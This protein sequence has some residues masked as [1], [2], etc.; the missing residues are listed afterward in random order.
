MILE[1]PPEIF[2]TLSIFRCRNPESVLKPKP[3]QPKAEETTELVNAPLDFELKTL[4]FDH[5]Y[6]RTRGFT[7]KTIKEFGLGY[8]SK[9]Y[10]AGRIAIPLHDEQ[11]QLVGYAGRIVDDSLVSEDNPRYKFPGERARKG[12]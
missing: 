2:K 10:L 5:P 4:G 9:G 1:R 8:C 11:G 12:V 3:P 6:L 7:E